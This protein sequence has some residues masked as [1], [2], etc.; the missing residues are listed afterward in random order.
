MRRWTIGSALVVG[1]LVSVVGVA[2]AEWKPEVMDREIEIEEALAAGPEII[3]QEAGVYVLTSSG[4]KRAR[5]S[6][7]G[8]NCII[9]RSQ[10]GAYEPQ[11]FDAAGSTSLLEQVLMRGQMQMRGDGP[12]EIQN[13]LNAAWKSGE[14]VP[15][16]RPGINYMLSERNRVPVGPDTVIP[17]GPHLMFYA[18]DLTDADIGGDLTGEGSPVFMINAGQPSGY[19]IVPVAGHAEHGG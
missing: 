14:L 3:R 2:A 15:P 9:G 6:S 11:C 8:F 13:A 17:Y 1:W 19:V 5:E 4:Y 10:E 18:P 16:R 7:N 12:D